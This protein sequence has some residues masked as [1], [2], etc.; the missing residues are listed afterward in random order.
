MHP[1]VRE[2]PLGRSL[3]HGFAISLARLTL[4]EPVVPFD[5]PLKRVLG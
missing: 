1:R 3:E 4:L 2:L 5:E